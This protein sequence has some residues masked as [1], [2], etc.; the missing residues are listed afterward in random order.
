MYA[1]KQNDSAANRVAGFVC[2]HV[3]FAHENIITSI[4]LL[5]DKIIVSAGWDKR[6]HFWNLETYTFIGAL[7]SSG[8]VNDS[9]PSDWVFVADAEILSIEYVPSIKQFAISSVDNFV[10]VRSWEE[11]T[12]NGNTYYYSFLVA[13]LKHNYEVSFVRHITSINQWVTAGQDDYIRFW[14]TQS[15]SENN[16]TLNKT[17]CRIFYNTLLFSYTVIKVFLE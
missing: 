16:Q 7:D 4:A 13:A 10:Y 11:K 3:F 14:S 9:N 17:V 5:S 15:I 8:K 1:L 6:L 2:K 12:E